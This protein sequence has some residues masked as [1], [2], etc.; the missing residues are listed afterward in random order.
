[1][2]TKGPELVTDEDRPIA[3]FS[4]R[5][6]PGVLGGV[7]S[8]VDRAS[9]SLDSDSLPGLR[10][11][12]TDTSRQRER[13][14]PSGDIDGVS[15]LIISLFLLSPVLGYLVVMGAASELRRHPPF[16]APHKKQTTKQ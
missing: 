10:T 9:T 1:M 7:T 11:S 5:V 8:P 4:V 6:V 12:F 16:G 14:Q 15:S 3:F 13:H 2:A